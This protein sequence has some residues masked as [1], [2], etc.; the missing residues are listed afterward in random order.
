[1]RRLVFGN[2]G[3]GGLLCPVCGDNI[4]TYLLAN[5]HWHD[6]HADIGPFAPLPAMWSLEGSFFLRR[7]RWPTAEERKRI[8]PHPNP[9]MD[10]GLRQY[11]IQKDKTALYIARINLDLHALRRSAILEYLDWLLRLPGMHIKET[12]DSY[13]Q[14][15]FHH[16]FH[17]DAD[18]N[19]YG[20]TNEQIDEILEKID[21]RQI[22]TKVTLMGTRT[23]TGRAWHGMQYRTVVAVTS[24]S[25]RHLTEYME[26]TWPMARTYSPGERYF[27]DEKRRHVAVDYGAD[28][29]LDTP[30]PEWVGGFAG[31]EEGWGEQ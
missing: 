2:P 21:R 7:G 31:L 29:F 12:K 6:R 3:P 17:I 20:L 16:D 25:M 27:R 18:S 19:H 10:Y 5:K 15:F 1:M 30:A 11:I 14:D 23:E 26:R 22:M 4:A 24:R 9:R 8:P 28:I 13:L